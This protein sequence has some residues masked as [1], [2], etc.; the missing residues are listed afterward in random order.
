MLITVL[1]KKA[2]SSLIYMKNINKFSGPVSAF[3]AEVRGV[4]LNKNMFFQFLL[5]KL[6][7]DRKSALLEI[8]LSPITLW[9][10]VSFANR[11]CASTSGCYL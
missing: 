11:S 1:Y 9:G 3:S 7:W 6:C 4:D 10:I 8:G 5:K 2:H